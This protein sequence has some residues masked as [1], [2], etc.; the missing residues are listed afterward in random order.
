MAMVNDKGASEQEVETA[1]RQ[2]ES[3]IAKHSIQLAELMNE[4]KA[5][6]TFDWDNQFV[7][8]GD[9]G[10][11][12]WCA[13]SCPPWFNTLTFGVAIFTDCLIKMHTK[14][15]NVGIGVGFY[16]EFQDVAFAVWLTSYLRNIV[17]SSGEGLSRSDKNAFR[18][19]MCVK[20]QLRMKELRSNRDKEFKEA[21]TAMVL[22][23]TKISQRDE[24][25]GKQ[26]TKQ[27]TSPSHKSSF[28][29]GMAA[30]EKIQFNRP[31]GQTKELT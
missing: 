20:L 2:A 10:K 26:R 11:S 21:G 28:Q 25:F 7:P 5:P 1:L 24:M 17:F 14:P 27:M 30:G 19:G 22:V 8:Y 13:K 23:N 9:D 12:K 3:L 6:I 16:G 4:T 31:V 15:N 18:R 29:S